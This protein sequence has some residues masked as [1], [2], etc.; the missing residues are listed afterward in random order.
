MAIIEHFCAWME[1]EKDLQKDLA[2]LEGSTSKST[3]EMIKTDDATETR[4]CFKCQKVGHIAAHCPGQTGG[5]LQSGRGGR[6]AGGG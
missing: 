4:T 6:G 5:S 3:V 2:K 1:D